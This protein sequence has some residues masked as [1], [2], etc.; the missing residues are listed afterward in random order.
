[1]VWVG[2]RSELDAPDCFQKWAPRRAKGNADQRAPVIVVA[3]V[4]ALKPSNAVVVERP[5]AD[6]VALETAAATAAPVECFP[7]CDDPP[8]ADCS[9]ASVHKL[10][11]AVNPEPIADA[12]VMAA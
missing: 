7:K 1:M 4:D 2:L 9:P 12:Q 11:V 6:A 3:F 10:P 8:V 5:I